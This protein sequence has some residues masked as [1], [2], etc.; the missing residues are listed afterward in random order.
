MGGPV[1]KSY[2][3]SNKETTA[4]GNKTRL[5]VSAGGKEELEFHIDKP[6]LI[7]R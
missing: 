2:Y 6:N 1:P 4:E 3:L 7:L 5:N